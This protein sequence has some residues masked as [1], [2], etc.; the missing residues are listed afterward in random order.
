M[1]NVPI[2]TQGMQQTWW[3]EAGTIIVTGPYWGLECQKQ[4]SRTGT[5]NYIPQYLWDV[6]TCPCPWYLLLAHKSSIRTWCCNYRNCKNRH[7]FAMI[8]GVHVHDGGNEWNKYE[9][10]MWNIVA[11]EHSCLT[12]AVVPE[13]PPWRIWVNG[14]HKSS[15]NWQ[16]RHNK[17]KHIKTLCMFYGI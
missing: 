17:T 14:S 6:I 2:C 3:S 10:D 4:V 16:Y 5:S 13:K 1:L 11:E 12:L 7:R 15:K 9:W 8:K